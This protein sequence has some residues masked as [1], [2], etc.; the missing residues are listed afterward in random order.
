MDSG[1]AS[2]FESFKKHF[3]DKKGKVRD[4]LH[5][6]HSIKGDKDGAKKL[7]EPRYSIARYCADCWFAWQN[8]LGRYAFDLTIFINDK[9]NPKRSYF[10][11]TRNTPVLI[12]MVILLSPLFL[13]TTLFYN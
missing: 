8:F 11:E 2:M 7:E 1:Y 4:P 13:A 9:E 5:V 12:L 6:L 10:D 3:W